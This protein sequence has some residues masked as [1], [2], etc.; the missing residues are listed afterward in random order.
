MSKFLLNL[1]QISKALLYSKINFLFRKEC[2]FTFGPERPSGQ[3]TRPASQPGHPPWHPPPPT[4]RA[5]ALGPSRPPRPWRNCQK[6]HLLRVC[7]AR[8]LRI[9][10][11]SPPHGPHLS[12]SSSPPRRRPRLKSPPR[13]TAI[14]RPAPPASIIA[15]PIKAPYSPA[16]IPPLESPLTPSPAIN[17]IGRKSPTV[18][19]QHFLPGAP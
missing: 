14:D 19:H 11:L 15:M 17:G 12:A 9:L 18:T 8:R 4:G 5:R 10:P 1:L 7:A 2:F 16:L 6:P 3:L 13:L